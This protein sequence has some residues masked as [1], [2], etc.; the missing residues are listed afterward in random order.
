M[1]PRHVAEEEE[2]SD[3][4]TSLKGETGGCGGCGEEENWRRGCEDR[5]S[6]PYS[7]HKLRG[8]PPWHAYEIRIVCATNSVSCTSTQPFLIPKR[9]T[10]FCGI[11][12]G[13]AI[14]TSP[15]SS[16]PRVLLL[17]I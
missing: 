7:I 14:V 3:K 11:L 12:C 8:M 10:L 16:A 4:G 1:P 5:Q 17:R 6:R 13:K 2:V 15:R 9:H